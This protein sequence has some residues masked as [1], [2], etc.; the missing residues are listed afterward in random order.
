MSMDEET[1]QKRR[2]ADLAARAFDGGYYVTGSFLSPADQALVTGGK[3]PIGYTLEGGYEGAERRLIIFGEEA[4]FGYP[5]VIPAGWLKI[6]PVAAKFADDLTHRDFLGSLMGLGISREVLGDILIAQGVGYLFCSETIA[7]YIAEH[8]CKIRHTDVTV[9]PVSAPPSTVVAL[10]PEE[11]VVAGGERL[12]AIIASVY[13][14]SR[15]EAEKLFDKEL[16]MMDGRTVKKPST[17]PK[18]ESRISVRGFGRFQYLGKTG[19]TRKGR[20]R[21]TLRIWR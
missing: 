18:I 15:S 9:T 2:L 17:E 3:W 1:L 6:A 11:T 16:V 4:L 10:P 7:P 20:V 5:P 13:D 21:M 8:L 12:D 19:E 14:L